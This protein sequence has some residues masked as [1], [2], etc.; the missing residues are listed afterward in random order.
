MRKTSKKKLTLDK[1]TLLA[2]G[3]AQGGSFTPFNQYPSI[4]MTD[5]SDC[6]ACPH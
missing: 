1:E 6:P 2:L 3:Q 4:A 5:C